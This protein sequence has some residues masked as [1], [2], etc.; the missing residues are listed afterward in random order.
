[1]Y[2]T[3]EDFDSY[4]NE[5]KFTVRICYSGI[6]SE[7]REI[8]IQFCDYNPTDIKAEILRGV[9][10]QAREQKRQ[11]LPIRVLR[12]EMMKQTSVM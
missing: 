11:T 2:F 4:G 3:D 8:L 9:E 5:D 10:R 7:Y 12:S 1:M 6:Y